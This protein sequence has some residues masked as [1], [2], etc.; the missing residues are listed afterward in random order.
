M[1]VK[2]YGN[3]RLYDT[4]QSRYITLEDLAE[5]IRRG[6]GGEVRVVDAKSGADLT[7]A[8]LAQII[9]ESRNAWRLLP[10]PMLIQLVRMGDS[11]FAEFLGKY[12]T[13][14]L[15][16][17]LQTRKGVQAMAPFNPFLGAG[18][19]LSRLLGFGSDPPAEP[20]SQPAPPPAPAAPVAP[21]DPQPAE[22]VAALRREFEELKASLKKRRR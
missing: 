12:M 6:E 1:L 14:A 3:R 20:V 22:D 7:T 13:W 18:T 17:Y 16:A 9:V 21:A 8:T 15:E 4:E 10:K 11:A 19:G 2:K 5:I